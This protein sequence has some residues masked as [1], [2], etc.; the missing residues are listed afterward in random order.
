MRQD[1][2][3]RSP[4]SIAPIRHE[5]LADGV[6][7]FAMTLLV[8]ELSIPALARMNADVELAR[9]LLSMWPRFLSYVLSFLTLGVFWQ[10]HHSCLEGVCEYDTTLT[11][12]NILFLMFVALVPFPTAYAGLYG[13]VR[14]TA[15]L[16]GA[17]L[18]VLFLTAWLLYAYIISRH[19]RA[20]IQLSRSLAR[21]GWVMGLVYVVL[22]SAGIGLAFA[23]PIASFS[24][25]AFIVVVWILA[26]VFGRAETVMFLRLSVKEWTDQ[27]PRTGG[28]RA[29]A[30]MDTARMERQ[31]CP[32]NPQS[33]SEPGRP[34]VRHQNRVGKTIGRSI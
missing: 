13:M 14:V 6:F 31:E 12:L 34:A 27:P 9:H 21:R 17:N 19:G 22:A 26:T 18:L 11:W 3:P 4:A 5:A 32:A 20:N 15:V 29:Q 16:Y 24:V 1:S 8:M 33:S 10:I 28:E 30:E 23:S 2:A 25:Y 7:A